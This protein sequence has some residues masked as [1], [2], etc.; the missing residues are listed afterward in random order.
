MSLKVRFPVETLG[1]AVSWRLHQV[2]S[3]THFIA[4]LP[5]TLE[6]SCVRLVFY[7]LHDVHSDSV[8][9]S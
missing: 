8:C 5:V 3:I 7:Q 1:Q 9:N 4:S 6:R 2:D